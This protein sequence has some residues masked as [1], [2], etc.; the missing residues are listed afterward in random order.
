MK[1]RAVI[2]DFDFTLVDSSRGF[3]DCHD[4]ACRQLAL[5]PLGAETSMAMMGTPLL[6]AF[7]IL[8]PEEHHSL[9][10]DY[11][12]LWQMRAD[13]VMTDL[14]ELYPHAPDT[15]AELRRQG[16]GLG[17]VSQKLRRRIEAVL[18]RD[19]LAGAFDVVVG[20]EDI[21]D[22]KPHPEGLRKAMAGLD[23]T[24]EEA[25]YAGDTVIDAQAAA[26]AGVA[27]VAVLSGVTPAAAFA[28]F[29]TLAV[30]PGIEGLPELCRSLS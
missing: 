29:D 30:L 15:M 1:L 4:Y 3:I 21:S 16:L 17:I 2:F 18:G 5:P 12:R 8:Y 7:K 27:F 13:E 10:E 26:N 11:V 19:G 23:V 25:I 28:P 14:T 20:G 9:A 24:P 6:E 22:F